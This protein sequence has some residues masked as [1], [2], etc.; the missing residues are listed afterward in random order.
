M[1]TFKKGVIYMKKT[2]ILLMTI[3]LSAA[4]TPVYAQDLDI[5]NYKTTPVFPAE[6]LADA[7]PEEIN[8]EDFA[9]LFDGERSDTYDNGTLRQEIIPEAEDLPLN[10]G[11]LLDKEQIAEAIREKSTVP[12]PPDLTLPQLEKSPVPSTPSK[13][14]DETGNQSRGD[15]VEIQ[16]NTYAILTGENIGIAYETDNPAVAV[17]TQDY[18]QQSDLYFEFY[19]NPIAALADY[20]ENGYHLNIYDRENNLDILIQVAA[21][22]WAEAYP[23]STNLSDAEIQSLLVYLEGSG[24]TDAATKTYGTAGNNSYFFFDCSESQGLV[25]LFTSVGGYSIRIHY[26]ASTPD[27]VR[28]G[29]ELLEGLTI[30]AI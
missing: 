5:H 2:P 11:D 16:D 14:T 4:L 21:A 23:D 26:W 29:L 18:L 28:K 1:Y 6:R 19:Q 30:A 9:A 27:E 8:A 3:A 20:F 13:G 24:F 12:A 10:S 15:I 22:G 17:I 7:S 25:C